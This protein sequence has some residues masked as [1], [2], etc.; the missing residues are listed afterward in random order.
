MEK[1]C[2][3]CSAN[4]EITDEDLRFYEEVSP[5]VGGVKLTIPPPTLCPD[6]RLQRRMAWRNDRTLH[7]RKSDLTGKQ[8]IAMYSADK[9]YKV[10]DQD[11]WWSDQWDA[12]DYGRDFDFSRTF[13]EQFDGLSL[14]VPHMSLYTTQAEN[15]YYT[16]HTLNLKN[17]YLIGGG[18]NSENC[19][20]G[21]FIVS[22]NDVL[23][24]ASLFSCQWCY[25]GVAS[26][27]CY[28]CLYFT[29]CR[30]CSDCLMV[31]D[32]LSCKNCIGCFG[33]VNKEYCIFNEQL[34]QQEYEKRR[35]ELSVLT[36]SIIDV[37]R[38]KLRELS[39]RLPHRSSHIFAS[40][41][42]SG[43]MIFNSKNCYWC[44]DISECED[45]KFVAFTPKGQ[46]TYDATFTA[47][48]PVIWSYEV[49]ST[50]GV[51]S[52]VCTY[53]AWFGDNIFYSTECHHCSNVFGC[54]G[55]R[56]KQFCIFNRQY[57]KEAYEELVPKIV[58]HMRTTGEWGE[59]FP[60]SSSRFCYNESVASDY[61]P[62]SKE[63]VL[64]RGWKWYE[65]QDTENRYLGPQ[66]TLPEQITK[67]DDSITEQ[68]LTCE[69]S[70]KP[71]KI[72][73]QE[74]G[75]YRRMGL[76]IPRRSPD[77]RHKERLTLRNPRHLWQRTCANCGKTIE[78]NYSPDHSERIYCED[79]YLKTVY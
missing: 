47:P 16:N 75:F 42:C 51:Q 65:G 57:T 72:T 58:D 38:G 71:Y 4:F 12:M 59:Y 11:E 13:M 40:E 20:Y 56:N 5:T 74:L 79:C 14:D 70:G 44:F 1:I 3:Q 28:Q 43:D 7:H 67:I 69:I 76:P 39:A 21:R 33:L 6:C 35:E 68:I 77:Q 19:M 2:H 36:P 64:H 61:F 23:D 25:E 18:G 62:L 48:D 54:I 78:T 26:Q 9:P 45:D 52:A 8:I 27:N 55:L 24:G 66:V 73:L 53:L 63:E 37:L 22:C 30:N 17:S 41:N 32:C 46:H 34:A 15:S 60:V 49:G 10:Y 29:N 31:E 50:V